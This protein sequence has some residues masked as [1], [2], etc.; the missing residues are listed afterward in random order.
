MNISGKEIKI[1]L[2]D[3]FLQI[4]DVIFNIF[5]RKKN[6][7]FLFICLFLFYLSYS[8]VLIY[9][10]AIIDSAKAVVDYYFSFDNVVIFH[11]GRENPIGH[12]LMYEISRPLIR[13]GYFILD[14]FSYKTKTLAS[15]LF[16]TF[17]ISS[18]VL[19]VF[20]YLKN[21]LFLDKAPLYLLTFFFAFFSTNLILCFTSE[22]FTLSAF[23]IS[24]T[25]YYYSKCIHENK[26]VTF[27]TNSFLAL[28][29]GSVTVTN[30]GK[31]I[32]PM[33]FTKDKL[34][35]KIFKIVVI[36]LIFIYILSRLYVVYDSLIDAAMGRVDKFSVISDGRPFYENVIDIFF[37]S[38]IFFPEIIWDTIRYKGMINTDVYRHW[39]QYLFIIVLY[40]MIILAI[41]RN[42]RNKL[43]WLLCGFFASDLF[44]HIVIGYGLSEG[45]IY[46]GHWVCLIPLFLGL[47]YNS[48]SD[49]IRTVLL[50]IFVI[51]LISIC[52]NNFTRMDEFIH[53]ALEKFPV[54]IP[55]GYK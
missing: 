43:L 15:V 52:I 22:T 20:K 53:M 48:A 23:L 5:P 29:L 38:T 32:F 46:G 16:C 4:M 10:S 47:L 37:G 33:L 28:S 19:Y 12:P 24:F 25:I 55:E 9:N 39:W 45:F 41:I 17:L 51:L 13:F 26:K 44:I 6:E 18:S 21:I 2:K 3:N 11:Y 54:S 27:L 40:G 42:Y 8:L 36:C 49:K 1:M 34:G 50:P 14:H 31:G 35:Y 7:L 30:F